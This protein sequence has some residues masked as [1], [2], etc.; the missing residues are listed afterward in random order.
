MLTDASVT[1]I[2]VH[3]KIKLN[4]SWI[5]MNICIL[6]AEPCHLSIIARRVS[7]ELAGKHQ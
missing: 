5:K 6:M 3:A 4:A 2:T 7:G 1:E